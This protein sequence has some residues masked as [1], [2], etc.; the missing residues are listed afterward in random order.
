MAGQNAQDLADAMSYIGLAERLAAPSTPRLVITHGLAGCG[1]TTV[2]SQL[3]LHDSDATTLRLRSDVERKRLFGLS[4]LQR[5]GSPIDGGIYV[6]A[7]HE[8]TYDRLHDV[9][10]ALLLSGW[11]VVV[12]AAFLRRTERDRFHALAERCGAAFA[13]LAPEVTL[14]KLRERITARQAAGRD[15]SEATLAVLEKQLGWIE[16]LDDQELTFRLE[17]LAQVESQFGI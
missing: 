13:I 4:A 12:D 11:S 8:R 3:L 5:S 2:S 10:Q 16:P 17:P 1:K 6:P 14:E 7:V 9:A 15:A